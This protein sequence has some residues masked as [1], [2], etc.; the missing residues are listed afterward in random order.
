MPQQETVRL[1]SLA[2]GD[3][4]CTPDK[5]WEGVVVHLGANVTIRRL[6]P[7]KKKDV[8]YMAYGKGVSYPASMIVIKL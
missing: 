6:G 1:D 2:I 4:F 5:G 7:V 3:K 8:E